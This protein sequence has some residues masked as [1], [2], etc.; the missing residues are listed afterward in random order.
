MGL[1]TGLLGGGQRLSPLGCMEEGKG[2]VCDLM[3]RAM[4]VVDVG[5]GD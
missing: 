5:V 1:L 3:T 2:F 4:L